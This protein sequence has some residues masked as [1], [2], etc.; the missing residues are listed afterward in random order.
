MGSEAESPGLSASP[1][2][3]EV[4]TAR[5]A[6]RRRSG[7]ESLSGIISKRLLPTLGGHSRCSHQSAL[8]TSSARQLRS[9]AAP[10]IPMPHVRHDTNRPAYSRERRD[11]AQG[12]G[13]QNVP[14]STQSPRWAQTIAAGQFT[15]LAPEAFLHM[16]CQ[17]SAQT[18]SWQ[19]DSAGDRAPPGI[20]H[21]VDQQRLL[22]VQQC[23]EVGGPERRRPRHSSWCQARQVRTQ[24]VMDVTP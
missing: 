22:L 24:E 4:S 9:P 11:A 21:R 23:D 17:I 20:E 2:N 6:R 13:R 16:V 1:H 12:C 8:P 19:P 7:T 5:P 18:A 10:L 3:Y 15:H 14:S